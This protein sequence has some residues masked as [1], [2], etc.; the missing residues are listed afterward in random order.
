MY[1]HKYTHVEIFRLY[2]SL[3]PRWGLMAAG[4]LLLFRQN[5]LFWMFIVKRAV[6][7]V[8]AVS[9][10]LIFLIFFGSNV[11]VVRIYNFYCIVNTTI[12]NLLVVLLNISWYL[13]LFPECFFRNLKK[14]FSTS[15]FTFDERRIVPYDIFGAV[16]PS[17]RWHQFFWT[18]FDV[19]IK[20]R[21]IKL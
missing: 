5:K 10:M 20:S 12:A 3:I 9:R 2:I 11:L 14:Y 1:T 6:S 21:R 18:V 15:V 8:S 16:P 7:G 19:L 13:W 17:T 4:C